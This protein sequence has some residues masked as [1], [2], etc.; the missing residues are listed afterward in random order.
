MFRE[1][2]PDHLEGASSS[3]RMA[4]C[5]PRMSGDCPNAVQGCMGTVRM[6]TGDVRGLPACCQGCPGTVR[7]LSGNVRVL[8]ACCPGMS[9]I[10]VRMLSGDGR[11]ASMPSMFDDDDD[12]DR[13]TKRDNNFFTCEPVGTL[14]MKI[15]PKPAMHKTLSCWLHLA[16]AKIPGTQVPLAGLMPSSLRISCSLPKIEVPIS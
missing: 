12:D 14:F 10:T 7:M 11:F 4:A 9:G 15:Y 6:L 13:D 5:C 8:S 3:S 1:V 2:L 16:T